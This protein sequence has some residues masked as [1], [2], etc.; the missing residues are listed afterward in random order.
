MSFEEILDSIESSLEDLKCEHEKLEKKHQELKRKAHNLEFLEQRKYLADLLEEPLDSVIGIM[1]SDNTEFWIKA[2]E[3]IT[4]NLTDTS[5]GNYVS[6]S[7]FDFDNL[8]EKQLDAYRKLKHG[9]FFR[10]DG[11]MSLVDFINSKE[12]IKE[13]LAIYSV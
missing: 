2:Y 11:Y 4:F 6:N 12:E 3:K 10:G 5:R 9:K 13:L 7:I 8:T 1:G